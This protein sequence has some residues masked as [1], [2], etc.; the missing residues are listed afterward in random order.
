MKYHGELS[1]EN[2]I[3]S[4]V[5]I[6]C[7]VHMWN[8]HR[9]TIGLYNKSRLS[10]KKLLKWNGFWYFIGVYIINRTFHGRLEIQYFSSRLISYFA[11]ERSERVKY[12]S[13][14]EDK[15]HISARPCNILYIKLIH[16]TVIYPVDSAIHFELLAY[17]D[18]TA[19]CLPVLQFFPVYPATQ[20][21]L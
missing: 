20:L 19:F 1:C 7:Y 4:R 14:L 13:P 17:E 11:S 18:N 3:S 15:F 8:D 21:Q 10:Q 5:K 16:W 6:I 12:Y 9:S 2:M